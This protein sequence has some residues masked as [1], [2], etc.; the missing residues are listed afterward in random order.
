MLKT[1]LIPIAL[2]V[3]TAT[4][5]T[6]SYTSTTPLSFN[7]SYGSVS[8]NTIVFDST[9]L[10]ASVP[11]FDAA[12]G[13]L[14]GVSVTWTMSGT[15]SG[16]IPN[17]GSFSTSYGGPYLINGISGVTAFNGS[18]GNG[19]APGTSFSSPL[20]SGAV[21]QT[22][23]FSL[24]D[25]AILTSVM[26]TGLVALRWET[27]LTVTANPTLDGLNVTGNPT[28]TITYTYSAIPEASSFALGVLGLGSI[29][30]RRRRI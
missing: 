19:G 25:T 27:P 28:A 15:L 5:A 22:Q 16:T 1:I 30:L 26:G 7:E 11:S 9:F 2:T 12:L 8:G 21:S 29:C 13:T 14:E 24:A 3:A 20:T 23:S 4:A 17:G 10:S 6:I 18:T